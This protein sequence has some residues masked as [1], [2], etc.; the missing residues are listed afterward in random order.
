MIRQI[1]ADIEDKQ[2]TAVIS[3]KFHNAVAAGLLEMAKAARK[4]KGLSKVAD[5]RRRFL[6]QV[7]GPASYPAIAKKRLFSIIQS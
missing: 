4:N 3:A 6:Q 2:E 5:K 1:V 7:F